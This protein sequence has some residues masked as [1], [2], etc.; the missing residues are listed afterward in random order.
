VTV[1]N[2]KRRMLFGLP[3][4]DDPTA[5]VPPVITADGS[6]WVLSKMPNIIGGDIP[7]P[8]GVLLRRL[9]ADGSSQTFDL[10]GMPSISAPV[11]FGAA[12]PTVNQ[13]IY[14]IGASYDSE[15]APGPS[16]LFKIA[17][18]SPEIAWKAPLP[19]SSWVSVA[20]EGAVY[21]WGE[22]GLTRLSA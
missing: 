20:G 13:E 15:N 3:I 12:W 14:L 10:L 8:N 9:A 21:L 5:N 19:S 16:T 7:P 17:L 11:F 2:G 22:S 18:A 6:V 1:A 4:C